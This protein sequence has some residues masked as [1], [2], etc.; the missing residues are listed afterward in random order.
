MISILVSIYNNEQYLNQFVD[1]ILKQTYSNFEVLIVD[2]KSTDNTLKLLK[3]KTLMDKRFKIF[4]NSKRVGL[5][6][7]LNYLI[8]KA[9]GEYIARL[10]P[11]DYWYP[12]K[13]LYQLNFLKLNKNIQMVGCQGFLFKNNKEYK[14]TNYP[15]TSKE[16]KSKLKY[17]NLILH[18][19]ILIRSSII[20]KNLYN[21]N[22]FYLQDYELWCRL[23]DKYRLSNLNKILVKIN[24]KDTLN[25]KKLCYVLK[26]KIKILY[27][28]NLTKKFFYSCHIVIYT[29]KMLFKLRI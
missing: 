23:S 29:L 5:T 16:I 7:N 4:E 10:D 21:Y 27:T 28:L 8:S 2:D 25:I 11:D 24:Y 19:S 9:K 20:K 12:K 18:S 3:K 17:Q 6:Y 14:R 15:T 13:L 22:F 26:I 1:C